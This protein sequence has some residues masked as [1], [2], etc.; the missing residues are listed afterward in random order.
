[1]LVKSLVLYA[2]AYRCLKFFGNLKKIYFSKVFSFKKSPSKGICNDRIVFFT[3]F[4]EM[5]ALLS[6]FWNWRKPLVSLAFRGKERS[7]F[8]LRSK[9]LF[10]CL[11]LFLPPKNISL[12]FQNFQ[13][14]STH[15]NIPSPLPFI[16][17][18]HHNGVTSYPSCLPIPQCL[19]TPPSGNLHPAFRKLIL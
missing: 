9:S 3:Y 10:K 13:E 15:L 7:C 8:Y 16:N 19:Q 4:T 2:D 12:F 6:I 5:R 14:L 11:L 1:M 17:T 18:L